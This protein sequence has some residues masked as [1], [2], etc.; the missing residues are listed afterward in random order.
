M[1]EAT[2]H[3]P[4]SPSSVAELPVDEYARINELSIDFRSY[5]PMSYLTSTANSQLETQYRDQ[6]EDGSLQDLQIPFGLSLDEPPVISKS[7]VDFLSY[8][9]QREDDE[10][11]TGLAIQASCSNHIRHLK[12]TQPLLRSDHE[13]DWRKLL[14]DV[15][16]RTSVRLR[17]DMLP[18][19]PL[20]ISLDEAPEYPESAYAFHSQ[21]MLEADTSQLAVSQDALRF[22]A[23]TLAIDKGT[24]ERKQLLMME[25]SD[26]RPLV[27][28]QIT[29]PISPVLLP[30]EPYAPGPERCQIPI[31]SDPSSLLEEDLEAAQ[32]A[33]IATSSSPIQGSPDLPS[34]SEA[35]TFTP[36][37]RKIESLKVEQ[38]LIPS[39]PS[40]P[41]ATRAVVDL[42]EAAESVQLAVDADCEVD[43]YALK[44]IP[45]LFSDELLDEMQAGAHTA[46]LAI[47][48]E[49]LEQADAIAR[50]QVPIMD[51][52]IAEL[53]WKKQGHDST[54][55]LKY[56][57]QAP[58]MALAKWK[59]NYRERDFWWAPLPYRLHQVS[60]DESLDDEVGLDDAPWMYNDTDVP[61]AASYVWKRPGLAILR[62]PEEDDEEE[63]LPISDHHS[64]GLSEILRKRKLELDDAGRGRSSPPSSASAVDLVRHP[65][66]AQSTN[67]ARPTLL[68]GSDEP[69][70]TSALLENYVNL[71]A[72]KRQKHEVSWFFGPKKSAQS[73]ANVLS[74]GSGK[75]AQVNGV[76]KSSVAPNEKLEASPIPSLVES[77]DSIKLIVALTLG[78]GIL[79]WIEKLLP[80]AELVERDFDR[81]NTVTWNRNM[82]SRSPIISPLAA[83]ADVVVSPATGIILTTLIKVIQKPIPGQKRKSTIRERVEKVSTRYERLV[84]LV[85]QSNRVDESTRDLSA[86]ECASLA[87]FTGFVLGLN[88][89]SQVYFVGGGEETLAKWLVALV[90]R[91]SFEAAGLQKLLIDAETT[92]EL[93]LRRAGMNA[94]AAQIILAELK[95]IAN[96]DSQGQVMGELQ[97]FILMTPQER[98]EHF[99]QLMGGTTVLLR[100][101]AVLDHPWE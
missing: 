14:R 10:A 27:S 35:E 89:N 77:S 55:Q 23:A 92:W 2:V 85:S 46:H 80:Q 100:V 17:S 33:L 48:Q 13:S 90:Q 36:V 64:M 91:Y 12:V 59:G 83:E 101:G 79:E 84:V 26:Y 62:E 57:L 69:N 21:L 25:L 41:P 53:E 58:S 51:F 24:E 61:T 15:K 4:S 60:L 74:N 44:E 22:L 42:Q 49:R 88:P 18:L 47:G 82:V 66:K 97:R 5:N 50:V 76:P 34:L 54:Q 99:S 73:D 40:S 81:W 37:I 78:S 31:A 11:I 19:E 65:S 52:A 95:G 70:A 43:G 94:Y 86:S 39:N 9:A 32:S 98:V 45:E 28:R 7:S 87:E 67:A 68:I 38:P 93:I 75:H 72:A 56:L 63:Y 3:A 30:A 1:T 71:R 16:S 20:E 6:V 8:I 96:L 29:P